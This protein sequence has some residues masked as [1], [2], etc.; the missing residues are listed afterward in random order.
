VTEGARQPIITYDRA[1]PEVPDRDPTTE[2]DC[3][4]RKVEGTDDFEVVPGRRPSKMLLV[5]KL[6]SAVGAWREGGYERASRTTRELF[7]WWFE[8]VSGTASDFALYWGQREAIETLVYLVEIEQVSDVAD[9]IA[10]YAEVTRSDL[11]QDGV[12]FETDMDGR[13]F[14]RIPRA[15][16]PAARIELPPE[17]LA[18]FAAKMATGSGKTL[19]M[20]LVMVWSYFHALREPSSG[21]STN[22]LVVAP[23]VIVFER[24]RVDFENCAV[25]RNLPLIPPGWSFDMKVILRGES[26]EPGGGGNL[27]VTNI[28]QLYENRSEWTPI[29]A[30]DALLGRHPTGNAATQGRSVLERVRSLDRLMVL[31]DEAH[32]VHDDDLEWNKVLLGLNAGL[33]RGLASWVDFSA[34]PRFQDGAHFPWIVCDYPLAQA[35]EDQIVKTPMILD[36]VNKAG[37]DHVTGA[38]VVEKYGEWVVAGVDRLKAH[39]K[40]F[41]AIPGAKPVMFVMCESIKHADLIGAWLTDRSSGFGFKAGE[42]LVIHT[43]KQGEVRKTDLDDLRAAARD[44]DR[45][46]NA[47]R[48]VVSVMVLREGWDVRNVT[49]VL[50]LRPGTAEA[51]ILPEQAVGRGLRLMHQVGPE[52]QQVLEVLGT[53]GFQN[54]V[55]ELEGEGV[56]IQTL[57]KP[58]TLPVTVAPVRERIAFDITIPRTSSTLSRDYR[59]L[60]DFAPLEVPAAFDVAAIARYRGMHLK[61]VHGTVGTT[62]G[63]LAVDR[64]SPPIAGDLVAAIVNKSEKAA[65]LTGTFAQL[66]PLV[67]TYLAKRCFGEPLDLDTEPLRIFLADPVHQDKVADLIGRRLGALSV[68]TQPL[69][70]ERAPILLSETA[71]FLWRRQRTMCAHTIFNYV[72]TFNP[73]ETAFA[74]FVDGC[75]D[76]LRFA[77]LAEQF[78]GVSVRYLKLSGAMAS[79]YPDWVVVQRTERGE[80]NWIIETKGRVWEGTEQKDAAIAYWCEQVSTLTGDPWFY[81]RVDQ[82]VFKPDALSSFADLVA[83]VKGHNEG[84]DRQLLFEPDVTA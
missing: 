20:A 65:G 60:E 51:K 77:A 13:R 14:A 19:V 1:L 45:L 34:T 57:T 80:I 16:L 63:D 30:V 6:R 15:G 64:P 7:R 62:H 72:A 5:N 42:V 8:E 49:V 12:T 83:V 29:N 68:E 41:K 61:P 75:A 11:L 79:Y 24:L 25:F 38:E 70:L 59:R 9:L 21:L 27:F 52:F 35:V 10:R 84:T 55:R 3:Y 4:L 26:T 32:H 56:S 66:Y 31:N 2:P 17:G 76:V 37:P 50:G 46:D 40:A 58:P 47:V 43:D 44:I 82:P 28:Q 71:P 36:M 48:V 69:T 23:N 67:R 73:F 54:F 18:R 22:F 33:S 78:T 39:A 81:M 53:P 74:E